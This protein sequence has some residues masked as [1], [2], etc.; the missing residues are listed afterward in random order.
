M[1]ATDSYLIFLKN[2]FRQ[3]VQILENTAESFVSYQDKSTMPYRS[4]QFSSNPPYSMRSNV[5]NTLFATEKKK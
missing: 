2:C 5:E 1:T 4:F 3:L